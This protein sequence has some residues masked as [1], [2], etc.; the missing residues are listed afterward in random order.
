M[1][2][3]RP[4]VLVRLDETKFVLSDQSEDIRG[5]MVVDARGR[6]VG[7]IVNLFVD[8]D[9]VEVRVLEIGTPVSAG[10]NGA[11]R[12]VPIET[13][14]QV[15]NEYVV[16]D[17]DRDVVDSTAVYTPVLEEAPASLDELYAHYGLP[18]FWVDVP[19]GRP[20]GNV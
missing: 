12:L 11:R 16:I 19:G 10:S 5:R 13:V 6:R 3:R 15:D 8:L 17:R 2:N 20:R 7:T 9:E 1:A 14:L 4:R 18:P